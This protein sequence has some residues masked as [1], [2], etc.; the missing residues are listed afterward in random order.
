MEKRGLKNIAYNYLLEEI[1]SFHLAP[2]QAIIE[3]DVSNALNISRTPV[4][5]AF[6]QLESEGLVYHLPSR[7]TF[8]ASLTAQDIEEIFELR[9][10]FELAALKNTIRY[11]TDEEI[12]TVKKDLVG[13]R[14]R[15]GGDEDF[16]PEDAF[17]RS[18]RELHSLI[19]KYCRNSRMAK[20]YET[21]EIQLEQSRRLSAMAPQRLKKSRQEH[22]D[23]IYA[24]EARDFVNA[25]RYLSVHLQNIKENTRNVYRNKL[26]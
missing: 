15:D 12:Q 18:D 11:A 25:T 24:L 2:G 26:N 9:E 1:T 13:L 7:G 4:R 5:E 23:I 19:M 17:Y 6:K 20:F 14:K 16:S 3:Q 22:L 21:L 10:I 8:V